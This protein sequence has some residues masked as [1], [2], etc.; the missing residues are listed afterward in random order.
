VLVLDDLHWASENLLELIQE[1]V[2]TIAA[3]PLVI[4]CQGRPELR[5]QLAGVVASERT[6]TLEVGPLSL[7][8]TQRLAGS[9]NLDEAGVERAE[10][11]P[12][13]VE[14]LAAMASEGR[15]TA[16]IPQSLRALIGARL[17]L[18]PPEARR[19]VRVGAVVG[20]V[21]WD[22]VVSTVL[23][24]A[25]P[26]SVFRVLRTRGLVDEDLS[27][28]FVGARQ[29]RFHH[30][31]IREVAYESVSKQE[32]GELHSRVATWLDERTAE[33]AGLS[34]SVA[35]HLDRALSFTSDVSPLEAP[36]PKLVQ[37]A[38]TAQ[39]RAEEWAETNAAQ[40]E[41]LRFARRAAAL[42]ESSP[43]LRARSR[44]R[45]AKALVVSGLHEE[46]LAEA[47]KVLEEQ[48]SDEAR[49]YAGVARAQLARDRSDIAGIRAYAEP[50][51]G[52]A[53]A[54]GLDALEVSVLRLLAWADIAE[55]RHS[56]AEG[57][58]ARAAEIC[59]R[60]G[61]L[62]G[63][64]L[65]IGGAG[66]HAMWRGALDQ[67]E[68][69]ATVALRYAAE[70]GSL[71]AGAMTQS[72]LAH[73]RREQGRLEEAVEHGRERLRLEL[74]VGDTFTAVGACA[75]TLAQPLILLGQ[76]DEA[77]QVLEQGA[78]LASRIGATWFDDAIRAQRA[79][80]L[81]LQG[82]IAEAEAQLGA[83]STSG[84]ALFEQSASAHERAK[85]HA[86]HGRDQE[87][88][89]ILRGLLEQPSGENV[90]QAARTRIHLASFLAERGRADEAAELIAEARAAI[91][92]S[93]A[94]LVESQLDSVEALL[95]RG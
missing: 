48:P 89:A 44:A 31:L 54:A 49:A 2:E 63:A 7:E 6:Q 58:M 71:R 83:M 52:L 27:S 78:D 41:S 17:D 8:E 81:R 16:V 59:F 50:A 67:A 64:A 86:L 46:G 28:P 84:A 35:H 55:G 70:S 29:F 57:R 45:L 15:D 73:L 38:V 26:N 72:L 91:E 88:E 61:D 75:L 12:L 62:A 37:E 33:H 79:E 90:L 87:A 25:V 40:S 69:H 36:D 20:D 68:A 93:H 32:R 74:E 1:L 77:W 19:A 65:A 94:G 34:V 24:T 39:W 10:G 66:V 13:F 53:Q 51:L 9:L 60:R 80:I 43:T 18:L 23:G 30:A 22:A 76:L 4:V 82:R 56:D 11:N 42:A 14:E 3:V 95:V 47:E 21:F 85:L 5:E 92:G